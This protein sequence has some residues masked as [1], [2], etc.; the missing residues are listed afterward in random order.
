[1][2]LLQGETNQD[3]KMESHDHKIGEILVE[4]R[5]MT[6]SILLGSL[7]CGRH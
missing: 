2:S 5:L 6:S 3:T 4:E 1:M 7:K